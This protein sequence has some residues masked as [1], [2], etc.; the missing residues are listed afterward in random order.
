MRRCA[1]RCC[2]QAKNG[3]K[4]VP[5]LLEHMRADKLVLW[6]WEPGGAREP[7]SMPHPEFVK[8]LEA[9]AAAG[10]PCP[11]AGTKSGSTQH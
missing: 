8:H 1:W 7:V 5:A 6:G 10:T 3:G 9:W 11:R 2:N 4:D